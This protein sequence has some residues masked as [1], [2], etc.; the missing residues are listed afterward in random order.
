M[1][2]KTFLTGLAIF[3]EVIATVLY[4]FIKALSSD[5]SYNGEI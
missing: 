4:G 3:D 5:I 2:Q 1:E